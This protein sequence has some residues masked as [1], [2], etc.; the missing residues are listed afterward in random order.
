M[1][2]VGHVETLPANARAGIPPEPV[3]DDL[4]VIRLPEP[5]ERG[6]ADP[7]ALSIG[8]VT[9]VVDRDALRDALEDTEGID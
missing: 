3:A 6:I 5:G 7:V 8:P 1:D 9:A 2:G 4:T